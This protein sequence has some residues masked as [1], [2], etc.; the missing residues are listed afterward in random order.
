[1][2][3]G[4][5][6]P[7]VLNDSHVIPY[8]PYL[9]LKYGSHINVEY[10][11]GQKACKYIFKYLLKGM[12]NKKFTNHDIFFAGFEKAYVQV[13]QNRRGNAQTFD[14]DEIAAT[15]KVRYMTSMEAYMRLNSYQIVNMSHQIY[16]L[17]VHEENGQTIVLEDGHESTSQG[18]LYKDTKLL[19]FFRLC[20]GGD[21]LACSLTYERVPYYYS[22]VF[23]SIF[24]LIYYL[25]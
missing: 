8:N 21:E 7:Q 22:Y 6:I 1:M 12:M 14:Y 19:A 2:N 16:T 18:K 15:F 4:S 5:R 3:R 17:S 13:A 11:F 20:R 25:I 10:V 23:F 24:S 9:L